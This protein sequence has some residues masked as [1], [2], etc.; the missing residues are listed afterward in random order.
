[1]G[2][3]ELL[4]VNQEIRQLITKGSDAKEIEQAA[5]KNGMIRLLE[6]GLNKAAGGLTTLEEALSASKE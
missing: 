2:V 4:E 1:M 5:V 6:D 3:Y